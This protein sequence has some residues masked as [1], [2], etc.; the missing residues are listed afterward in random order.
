[1]SN[2]IVR[3]TFYEGM[4]LGADNLNGTVDHAR[5]ERA[6]HGRYLHSWGIA[7]GLTLTTE[8]RSESNNKYVDVTLQPGVAIDGTGREIVVPKPELLSPGSFNISPEVD[9]NAWFP[10]FLVG[11]DVSAPSARSQGACNTG[12]VSSTEESF[13]I[14]FGQLAEAQE[15]DIQ[16]VPGITRGPGGGKD[17]TFW[18][19][20]IGYVQWDDEI[21]KFKNAEN[22]PES[23]AKWY[24]PRYAGVKAEEVIS[25]SD[26]LVLRSAARNLDKKPI[27]ELDGLKD[28]ELRFGLQNDNGVILDPL[29][30]VDAQVI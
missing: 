29:L 11:L 27:I 2:E 15:L 23:V 16:T 13:R 19:I 24:W 20:L 9:P 3:P 4:I 26:R 17:Q 18:R 28:G 14:D 1:M 25:R 7:Y 8:S 21:K 6:R 12:E 22:K 5:N 10:V 30:K